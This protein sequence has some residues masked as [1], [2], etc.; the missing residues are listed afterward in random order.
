[1]AELC[2]RRLSVGFSR[3]PGQREIGAMHAVFLAVLLVATTQAN[4]SPNPQQLSEPP[5]ATP[6]SSTDPQQHESAKSKNEEADVTTSPQASQQVEYLPDRPLQLVHPDSTHRKLV[7]VDENVQHLHRIADAVAVVAVVG[8]YHSGKSF[9]LNQLMG[10][11]SGFG[12]GPSVRPKTMGIW[13]WGKVKGT[14]RYSIL[15][16]FLV[17]LASVYDVVVG[18]KRL[19]YIFGH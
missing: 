16:D 10:K 7:L 5:Q 11:S 3:H 8:K 18:K 6:P 17:I 2:V 9:L 1:M 19:C 14:E 12:V 4:D 13:M 15:I